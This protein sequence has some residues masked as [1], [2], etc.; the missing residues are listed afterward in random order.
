MNSFTGSP[1][2]KPAREEDL[3][4]SLLSQRSARTN[5]QATWTTFDPLA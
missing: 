5:I 4:S 1:P 2:F 3:L